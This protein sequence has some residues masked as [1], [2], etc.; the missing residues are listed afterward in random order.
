MKPVGLTHEF[1]KNPLL[2]MRTHS[3]SPPNDSGNSWLG[4]GDFGA[5]A[6]VHRAPGDQFETGMDTDIDRRTGAGGIRHVKIVEHTSLDFP[7]ATGLKIL[8]NGTPQDG[9]WV[10][11]YFLPWRSLNILSYQI[12]GVPQGLAD[13]DDEEYPRFFFTAGIN[14]CSVFAQG[15]PQSPTISH[16]GINGN[17]TRPAGEFWRSQMA[18]TKSGYGSEAIRGE[19]NKHEYMFNKGQPHQLANEYAKFLSATDG[20]DFKIEIQSPFGC[21]FGIRFGRSWTLYLQ[22]SVVFNKVRFYK[23]SGV[24]EQAR[25]NLTDHFAKDTGMLATKQ[26]SQFV[27]RRLGALPLPGKKEVQVFSTSYRFSMPL[28]VAEMY[29]NKKSLGDLRAVFKRG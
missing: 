27:G 23:Q 6:K 14:G 7:G 22:K 11:I 15:S 1:L 5:S 13:W 18:L 25:G 16:A 20:K 21:V 26:P 8:P 28:E 19:A 10:P 24:R 17:L 4:L 3:M 29:P 2:F 12:P 9:S